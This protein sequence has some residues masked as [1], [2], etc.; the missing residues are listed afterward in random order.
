MQNTPEP[1]Q[2]TQPT[3]A[4]SD[5]PLPVK[6]KGQSSTSSL[7]TQS[8]QLT[9]DMEL[10]LLVNKEDQPIPSKPIKLADAE[11]PDILPLLKIFALFRKV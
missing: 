4:T 5:A 2:H 10:P 3:D 9:A 11:Q 8:T 6:Q 7:P 1:V